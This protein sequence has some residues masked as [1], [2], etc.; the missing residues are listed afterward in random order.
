M[1]ELLA[2]AG[3]SDDGE[4]DDTDDDVSDASG[5]SDADEPLLAIEKKAKLLDKKR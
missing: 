5:D 3:D 1:I 2:V 4:G